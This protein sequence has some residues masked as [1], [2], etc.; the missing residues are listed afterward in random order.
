VHPFLFV[1]NVDFNTVK[2]PNFALF[3]YTCQQHESAWHQANSGSR[4]V[5]I[6]LRWQEL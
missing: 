5:Q 3:C 2:H 4:T 6:W 1:K